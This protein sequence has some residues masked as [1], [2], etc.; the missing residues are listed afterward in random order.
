MILNNNPQN[1]AIL[2]NVGQVGEFRIRNSAKAFSILSSGLYANKIRAIIREL[3][4][5]AVDSHTAAGKP[6][7]PFD[8]HLPNALEPWFSIRDYG[9]GLTHDQVTNIYT[10]YF[11]STKTDSNAFIGALGL[12][13]KSPFSYTDNFSVIA[14]R[15]GRR[16]IYT[17]F[18]NEHGVP[19]IALMMEEE[20]TEPNGV[21]V[22]FAVTDRWDFDKF[23]NEAQFVYVYF[24][25]RPVVHGAKDFKFGDPSYKDENIIPGVHYTGR[26]DRSIAVMGNIA[27]PIDVP[28]ADTNLGDLH[29]LLRCGLVM[30]FDIGELDFQASREGLSYIPSTVDAIKRKLTVLNA[31]LA[32][33]VANEADK[34]DNLW[35]RADYLVKRYNE[36]LFKA[37][38]AKYIQ[39]TKFPLGNSG[40]HYSIIKP[41]SL[42][43]SELA[44]KY[45]ITLRGFYKD[46]GSDKC[47]NLKPVSIMDDDTKQHVQAW[48]IQPSMSVH[49]VIT[50]TKRGALERAKFHWRN[51][52]MDV[53]NEHVIVI[54]AAD[55]TKTMSVGNF[56]RELHNPP[57]TMYAT[58]LMERDQSSK[59]SWGKASI[60]RFEERQRSRHTTKYVWTN[61]GT[62]SEFDSNKI[63]YYVEMNHWNPV[64]VPMR[65]MEHFQDCLRRSGIFTGDIYGV[66]KNDIELV[67]KQ[68]NWVELTPFVRQKLLATDTS[69][70]LGLVKAAIDF[71]S[72]FKY[73]NDN[74]KKDSPYYKLYAELKDV[75]LVDEHKM[76]H[77]EQLFKTFG[78]VINAV[79][80]QAMIQQYKIKIQN[81][82]DRYPML[83]HLSSYS[84]TVSDVVDYINMVDQVKGN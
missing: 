19:S 12:G 31:Q 4:C 63:Y 72:N 2:S 67:R 60:L 13:S 33:H 57:N 73:I 45:N 9:T 51:R 39:D 59:G 27:Y 14:I 43:V 37:A 61:A 65:T 62:A 53:H 75:E 21:E 23:R 83:K 81:L 41:F 76:H 77:L 47:A 3:S 16:G 29:G 48:S 36:G 78:I 70:V 15:D 69:N 55:K 46:R 40:N 20:T 68:K 38:T 54:E 1:Q 32:I 18:I 6:D 34:I 8:V 71:K 10:T 25:L 84:A 22:K 79:D 80:P 24:K 44:S 50:D 82:K 42:K 11:E 74:L 58:Q 30:E 64:G 5:N 52:K 17:A 66:R 7:L 35:E 28:Q 26:S 49:F 56:L